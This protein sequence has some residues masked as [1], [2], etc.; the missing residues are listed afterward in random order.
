MRWVQVCGGNI[1]T[2]IRH[3]DRTALMNLGSG[4]SLMAGGKS[5]PFC[6]PGTRAHRHMEILILSPFRR[7]VSQEHDHCVPYNPQSAIQMLHL[8]VCIA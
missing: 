6:V 8:S 4:I 1:W 3:L 2:R 5:F 7:E